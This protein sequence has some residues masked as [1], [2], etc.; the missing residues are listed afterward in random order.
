MSRAAILAGFGLLLSAAGGALLRQASRMRRRLREARS[1]PAH[2]GTVLESEVRVARSGAS[3]RTY[4]PH[5]RY[6]YEVG[7]DVHESSAITLG[8]ATGVSRG[9]AQRIVARY[10]AGATVRVHAD[11]RNSANACLELRNP[12]AVIA[13]FIGGA[14]A[15]AGLAL[16]ALGVGLL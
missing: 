16:V 11:P 8:G 2:F 5:V 10:P 15:A 3:G 1:W 13:A 12:N 7:G 14:S 6:R 4:I 9:R